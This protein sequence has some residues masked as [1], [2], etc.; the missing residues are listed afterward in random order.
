MT[1]LSGQLLERI[2][3]R[4][5]NPAVW[6]AALNSALVRFDINSPA[7]TAAFLAQVAHESGEL[8]RLIEN[9]NYSASGLRAVWPKRFPTLKLARDYER[10]PQKIAN[11]V[12]ANRLGNGDEA[13]G[14]G[15]RYRGRGIIQLTGRGNY[16]ETGGAI[17]LPLETNPDLLAQ[18][19]A[20]A[21]SAA[22]FWKSRG[23]NVLADDRNDDDDE[24]DFIA[25]TKRINGG[26]V[27]L[28]DRKK[29]WEQAK[30][31]LTSLPPPIVARNG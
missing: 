3:P 25:I 1:A 9:L 19:E 6:A 23:L 4:C 21:M 18:P 17:G 24:E 7:R 15:W 30:G 8:N 16:A 27:G 12:Y 22:Y 5:A 28:E 2:M 10:N 13:S 11:Y 29:Y 31:I 20:A 14:D 26:R